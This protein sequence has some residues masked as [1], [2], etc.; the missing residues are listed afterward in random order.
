MIFSIK[1]VFKCIKNIMCFDK[2]LIQFDI[3]LFF[4]IEIDVSNFDCNVVLYQVNFDD[5]K[6]FVAFESK[7]FNSIERNYVIHERKLLI[8]KETFKK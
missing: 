7:K 1:N 2:T 8:I 6:R 5:V 4:I 3:F